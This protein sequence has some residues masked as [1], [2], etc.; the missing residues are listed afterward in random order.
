MKRL[1]TGIAVSTL[2]GMATV[3]HGDAF[4][5]K[6][7]SAREKQSLDDSTDTLLSTMESM[8]DLKLL[9]M[10]DGFEKGECSDFFEVETEAKGGDGRMQHVLSDLYRRGICVPQDDERALYWAGTAAQGRHT[11]AYFDFGVFLLEG[12]GGEKRPAAAI[13]WLIK[14]AD[15]RPDAY[16]QLASIY[17]SGVGVPQSYAIAH[18]YAIKGAKRGAIRA[19][20][21]AAILTNI[22][23][24]DFYDPVEAYQWVLLA[25]ANGNEAVQSSLE[26]IEAE[27]NR[28]LS[29][30]KISAAQVAAAR[31]EPIEAAAKASNQPERIEL[32]KI[33]FADVRELSKT[34]A[35]AMLE[36]HGLARD[37][38]VFFNAIEE[39]N[40]GVV[41]LYLRAGASANTVSPLINDSALLH[42]A[43]N[44]SVSV[45]RLLIDAGADID[46]SV[47][48]DHD[49]PLLLALSGHHREVVDLLIEA[50]ARVDHPGIIYN[51]VEFDDPAL[52]EVLRLKGAAIDKEYVSTPLANAVA[53]TDEELERTCWPRSAS[54]L[55]EHGAKLDVVDM[56]GQSLLQKAVM[57]KNPTECIRVLLEGGA[58]QAASGGQAPLFIAVIKGNAET[59]ELLLEHDAD[60][61]RHYRFEKGEVPMILEGLSRSTV[62]N[63]GSLL[64]VAVAEKHAAIAR[65]LV[66]H[67]ADPDAKDDLDRSPR[68]I[69]E[70]RGDSLLLAVFRGDL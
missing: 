66:R 6:E 60:P 29:T 5:G 36:Q 19:Q 33:A 57:T 13:P 64:Q 52:L 47:N 11:P 65:H 51:A 20:V 34:R 56:L 45:V 50:G 30:E 3:A 4:F 12:V 26:E 63:G 24:L 25:K 14:T 22:S 59:V 46:G 44:G 35:N 7:L 1:V 42:A 37:R 61:Q 54:Y 31:F 55:I 8:G 18:D 38:F 39:D 32:P 16:F 21:M 58:S 67:G 28:T 17:V 9:L 43:R 27:L 53:G 70:E 68:S 23:G 40:L 62:M 69:A 15:E 10:Y 41:A 48:H 49:T 2:L